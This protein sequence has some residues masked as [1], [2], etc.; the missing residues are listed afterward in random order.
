M[1]HRHGFTLIELLVVIAIIGVL[2][3]LLLPA[4]QAAREAARRS[5]CTN[6]L[7]QIGLAVHNYLSA[8]TDVMPPAWVN[9][10]R[11][12][13]IIAWQN[14]SAH[15]RLLPYMEQVSV[16]NSINWM[17]GARW[18]GT[19]APN[20]PDNGAAGQ[21]WGAMNA[22]ANVTAI[23]SFL[24]P[25]DNMP[26]SSGQYVLGMPAFSK[27]CGSSNYPLN[28]GLNRRLTGWAPNGPAYYCRP[29]DGAMARIVGLRTF[30]DGTANTVIF[31]EWVKGTASDGSRID[32]LGTVFN[33]GFNGN[34]TTGATTGLLYDQL[35]AQA[36]RAANNP[37]PTF[38]WGWKGEWWIYGE[39]MCYQHTQLPNRRACFY[40]DQTDMNG[41][42]DAMTGSLV[43]PSSRHPGGVNVLMADGSVRFIKNTINYMAWYALATPDGGEALSADSF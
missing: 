41:S 16:Y 12:A 3:A 35:Y 25:S 34:D 15:A 2:I 6:N 8:N 26:G 38:N 17:V 40:N 11:N 13:N 10:Q 37:V 32:T 43:G 36:Q 31:S 22:T 1:K 5:Q 39:S 33:A 42:G 19:N 30:T 29:W 27:V 28:T 7:K 21:Q 14:Q 20:P 24:C 23:N 18:G 4:V 9:D